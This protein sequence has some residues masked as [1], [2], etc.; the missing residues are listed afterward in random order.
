[1]RKTND[2]ATMLDITTETVRDWCKR[3]ADFLSDNATPNMGGT[4]S[5]TDDDILIFTTINTLRNQ[6]MNHDQVL[7]QL[8]EGTR[9]EDV[10]VDYDQLLATPQGRAMTIQQLKNLNERISQLETDNEHML[11]ELRQKERELGKLEGELEIER[12]A[13]E[14]LDE[15]RS[16]IAV[17]RYRLKQ[18]EQQ[19]GDSD[20]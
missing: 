4:R 13:R 9:I 14:T 18:Y 15:L 19:E 16:E 2:V 1:M 5:F 17:L 8:N 10:G 20:A 3:Y 11:N 7:E 12:G 6:G